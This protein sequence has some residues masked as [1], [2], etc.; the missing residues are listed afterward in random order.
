LQDRLNDSAGDYDAKSIGCRNIRVEVIGEPLPFF[1]ES[2]RCR[3]NAVQTSFELIRN[4]LD[5]SWPL[6]QPSLTF[7]SIC[8]IDN[9]KARRGQTKPDPYTNRRS[10]LKPENTNRANKSA[11][12][13]SGLAVENP[14]TPVISKEMKS[15]PLKWLT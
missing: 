9:W 7:L 1:S 5:W 2:H 13:I 3:D 15:V 4:C 11:S 10:K 6:L 14:R 8:M 12:I